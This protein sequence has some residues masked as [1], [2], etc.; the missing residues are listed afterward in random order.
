MIKNIHVKKEALQT[1]LDNGF[2]LDSMDHNGLSLRREGKSQPLV[3]LSY[4]EEI[5]N[6]LIS[7]KDK[8]KWVDK[9]TWIFY[10]AFYRTIYIY[11]EQQLSDDIIHEG[12]FAICISDMN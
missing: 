6:V 12:K 3:E 7:D 1:L 5:G 2:V 10:C 9:V 8:Y 4:H 11:Y